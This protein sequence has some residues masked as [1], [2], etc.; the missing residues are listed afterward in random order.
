METLLSLIGH[1]QEFPTER[2]ETFRLGSGRQMSLAFRDNTLP[3]SL[4]NK[5]ESTAYDM[6]KVE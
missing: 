1:E 4:I 6:L 5:D 2:R 3:L